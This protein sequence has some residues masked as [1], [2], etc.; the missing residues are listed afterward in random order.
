MPGEELPILRCFVAMPMREEFAP[1]R[2]AVA[3]G[4]K[5]AGFQVVFFDE[6]SKYFPRSIDEWIISELSQVDCIIADVTSANP[7]VFFEL[8]IARAMGKGLFI[9]AN[10]AF[11]NLPSYIKDFYVIF[12]KENLL[13]LEKL[14]DNITHSLRDYRQ[15]PRRAMFQA[16]PPL[17]TPFFIDWPRIKD[18]EAE[19]LIRELLVQM[20][21][22]DVEWMAV[23]PGID[24]IA[25][26][27]RKD[28]DGL[29]YRELWL[30]NI[31]I[32]NSA[33]LFMGMH[34]DPHYLFRQMMKNSDKFA[35]HLLQ[36]NETPFTFLFIDYRGVSQSKEIGKRP[37]TVWEKLALAIS[38][39][40]F[41]NIRFRIWDQS[42]LT[43]LIQRF[44]QIGYKYFSDEGRI[45]SISRKTYEDLY[46]ENLE[47]TDRQARLI[48]ELE[49]EK[50][51][52]ISA[53]RDAVWKEISFAAAHKIGNPIFAIE[54]NLDPLVKR[55]RENKTEEVNEVIADI[56][57]SVDKAKSIIE[58][59]KSLTKAQD[60]NKTT[61]LL[62]P[63][64]DNTCQILIKQ[65]IACDVECQEDLTLSADPERLAECLDELVANAVRWLINRPDKKIEFKVIPILSRP[66]P[67]FLDSSKEYVLIVVT[68]NGPGIPEKNKEK[69]FNAFFTTYQHGTGLGLA[70][71][72]RIIEGHGGRIIETG[73]PGQG[74]VFEIYLPIKDKPL[75]NENEKKGAI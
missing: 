27:P 8:G 56:H 36:K 55:I 60:I 24:M 62:R 26:F 6:N 44:P 74:A 22:Q 63:M 54:T 12:Y 50:N 59:F 61:I 17:S 69:I 68:D 72:R 65:G 11:D 35:E 70:L 58:Q 42:Y 1:V 28:P 41:T 15:S 67:D 29:E 64:I 25:E 39:D 20:G 49:V 52:R 21:F 47:L 46:K 32:E 37:K 40:S 9:I 14:T 3:E 38:K 31:G 45:R 5:K 30:I 7:N 34:K 33:E 66:L 75:P 73:T 18:R 2:K 10:E 53:E 51:R 23:S 43:S 16:Q 57:L 4:A 71:V 13:G 48:S 19:N